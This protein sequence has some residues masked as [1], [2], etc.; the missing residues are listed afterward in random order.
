MDANMTE[1]YSSATGTVVTN[2]GP[3]VSV[4]LH[5]WDVPN[6]LPLNGPQVNERYLLR[7]GDTRPQI[8]V[9]CIAQGAPGIQTASFREV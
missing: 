1:V 3:Y 6:C 8:S 7:D 2:G 5:L 4:G 9:I